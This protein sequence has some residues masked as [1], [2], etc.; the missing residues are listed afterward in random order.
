LA[1]QAGELDQSVS[2]AIPGEFADD[3]RHQW[4]F[5][6]YPIGPKNAVRLGVAGYNSQKLVIKSARLANCG[7]YR[8]QNEQD[9]N[10]VRQFSTSAQLLI[11]RHLKVRR[12]ASSSVRELAALQQVVVV[13]GLP[14]SGSGGSGTT[15]PGPY[16]SF[17]SYPSMPFPRGGQAS[18]GTGAR[19]PVVYYGV[20]FSNTKCGVGVVNVPI[21]PLPAYPDYHFCIFFKGACPSGPYPLKLVIY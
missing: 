20:P 19:N 16:K 13:Y 8:Y 11:V 17:V 9:N 7:F 10:R 6:G 3:T 18:D 4:S 15:C 12:K 5:N 1:D 2:F 21:P 14:C